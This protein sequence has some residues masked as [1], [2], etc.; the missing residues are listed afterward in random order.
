MLKRYQVLLSEWL[1]DHIKHTSEKYD[2]SFS[3]I[4][5]LAL[6]LNIL[7]SVS[8][9]YPK[10]RRKLRLSKNL[11]SDIMSNKSKE[12]IDQEELHKLIS[13][14]YFEGRKATECCA[15]CA[16]VRKQDV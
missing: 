13:Q 9:V 15:K 5:R 14:V 7:K 4:I 10:C 8:E 2:I 1:A 16:K 12:D 3:E 6:C 11:F